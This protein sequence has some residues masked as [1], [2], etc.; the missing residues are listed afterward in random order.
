MKVTQPHFFCCIAVAGS[1]NCG[2]T[3]LIFTLARG[4]FPGDSVPGRFDGW[5]VAAAATTPKYLL[6]ELHSKSLAK[7]SPY[8]KPYF[9]NL[10]FWEDRPR[11]NRWE[12]LLQQRRKL[13]EEASNEQK[14]LEI[15]VNQ[16]K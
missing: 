9:V 13:E 7:S 6:N 12:T 11:L 16:D 4:I 3:S 14:Q 5:S 8:C 1:R 10:T 2:K 15:K